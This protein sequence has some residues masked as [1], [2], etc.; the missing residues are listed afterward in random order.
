MYDIMEDATTQMEASLDRIMGIADKMVDALTSCMEMMIYAMIISVALTIGMTIWGGTGGEENSW[1]KFNTQRAEEFGK[2][3]KDIGQTA[4]SAIQ[5]ICETIKAKM[6]VAMDM[7]EVKMAQ[8]S[9]HTCLEIVQHQMDTGSCRGQES[10]CFNDMRGCIREGMSDIKTAMNHAGNTLKKLSKS[11]DK[12]FKALDEL[13]GDLGGG[14]GDAIFGISCN[15]GSPNS[16]CC[17]TKGKRAVTTAGAVS[18]CDSSQMI[19]KLITVD[20]KYPVVYDA[21]NLNFPVCRGSECNNKAIGDLINPN[22][23]TVQTFNLYCFDSESKFTQN[24]DEIKSGE[25]KAAGSVP[26]TLLQYDTKT[27]TCNSNGGNTGNTVTATSLPESRCGVE[28]GANVMVYVTD[29]SFLLLSDPRTSK[30]YCTISK[31]FGPTTL[32]PVTVLDGPVKYDNVNWWKIKIEGAQGA[33][34]EGWYPE[35]YNYQGKNQCFIYPPSGIIPASYTFSG[36]RAYSG[37][38]NTCTNTGYCCY[39]T[40]INEEK[41]RCKQNNGGCGDMGLAECVTYCC[42][43]GY[44][45]ATCDENTEQGVL[46][47]GCP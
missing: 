11:Y 40:F 39:S 15:S 28:K 22:T 12:V 33:C 35:L 2:M 17:R 36:T 41:V 3:G 9:M 8:I 1:K 10:S 6:D 4:T 7:E 42:M 14:E 30:N 18:D 5:A 25:I 24:L 43:A 32:Y 20:C 29:D 46:P 47:M 23:K 31:P 16:E 38:E 44:A 27:C 37:S 34:T 26:V 21:N 13:T 45:G 19:I